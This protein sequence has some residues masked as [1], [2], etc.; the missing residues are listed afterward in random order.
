MSLKGGYLDIN[1]EGKLFLSCFIYNDTVEVKDEEL[2]EELKSLIFS[3]VRLKTVNKAVF[4]LSRD[5]HLSE[6]R[7]LITGKY[8]T[9]VVEFSKM[10]A[11][12]PALYKSLLDFKEKLLNYLLT[13]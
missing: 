11:K 1:E 12:N 6:P 13:L 8:S 3:S 10:K 4:Q 7:I 5:Q 9:K 2:K